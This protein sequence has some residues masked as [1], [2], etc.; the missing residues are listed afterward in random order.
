[1]WCR[2]YSECH[3]CKSLR[4][5][6]TS[7][8]KPNQRPRIRLLQ[9]LRESSRARAH[10]KPGFQPMFNALKYASA[11]PV[12]IASALLKHSNGPT[13]LLGAESNLSNLWAISAIVNSLYSFYWD[14]K[15]DWDL[16]LFSAARNDPGHPW[17]LRKECYFKPRGIYYLAIL[18]DLVL[19]LTW[20]MKLSTHLYHLSNIE[21]GVFLFELFEI[22]RR[23]MW[24]FL[25]VETEWIRQKDS[26]RDDSL[27]LVDQRPKI[28][29]D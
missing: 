4:D 9:C 15:Y 5:A 1:M 17:G 21:G 20:S 10:G 19:R 11:F 7:C 3:S 22:L 12:L 25:R 24:V 29:E 13:R 26:V 6:S 16:T 23:W 28:D 14:V 8:Y 27:P 18:V 2:F